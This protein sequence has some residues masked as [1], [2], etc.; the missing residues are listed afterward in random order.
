LHI[1]GQSGAVTRRARPRTTTTH[2][3][4]RG[5]RWH[6]LLRSQAT[7]RAV[8][9]GT[10]VAHTYRSS[11]EQPVL[12]PP[13]GT[14][15][16]HTYRSSPEQLA[17]AALAWRDVAPAA[18]CGS[19][20]AAAKADARSAAFQALMGLGPRLTDVPVLRVTWLVPP[21]LMA[22]R[23]SSGARSLRALALS[24]EARAWRYIGTTPQFF[25]PPWEDRAW[26]PSAG[27]PRMGAP[28]PCS[29]GRPW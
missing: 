26:W 3:Y 14:E 23:W 17:A 13:R 22:P 10:E 12:G 19:T 1:T 5:T 21:A 11:P 25:G 8:Q 9:R 15:V 29:G 2:Q 24:L 28:H 4:R 27:P 16:A 7:S 20:V 6:L 18:D